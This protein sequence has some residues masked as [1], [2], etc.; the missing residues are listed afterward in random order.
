[1]T[2]LHP[3]CII[4]SRE[5]SSGCTV[6]SLSL[7]NVEGAPSFVSQDDHDDD[8]DDADDADAGDDDAEDADDDDDD[9]QDEYDDDEDDGD[10]YDDDPL[11]LC[12]RLVKLGRCQK[13]LA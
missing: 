8:A 5:W 4:Y 6:A 3:C 12:S 2:L 9:D 13:T 1:M 10:L 11:E 7:N